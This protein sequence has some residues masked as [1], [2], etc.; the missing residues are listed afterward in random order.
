MPPAANTDMLMV[1]YHVGREKEKVS[2][3]LCYVQHI[4]IKVDLN[5]F[6]FSRD[7]EQLNTLQIKDW[8]LLASQ[9]DHTPH[10]RCEPN[11]RVLIG[12]ILPYHNS[13]WHG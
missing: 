3:T 10:E 8:W 2:P 4:Y 9:K 13:V 1:M 7:L 12:L 11:R 6:I 5:K